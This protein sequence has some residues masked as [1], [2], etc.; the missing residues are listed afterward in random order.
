M[1]SDVDSYTLNELRAIPPELSARAVVKPRGHAS[2]ILVSLKMHLCGWFVGGSLP[3]SVNERMN[4]WM[5]GWMNECFRLQRE[6]SSKS[7]WASEMHL[8]ILGAHRGPLGL[9]SVVWMQ[10]E[11]VRPEWQ[12]EVCA[13]LSAELHTRTM[14]KPFRI[15]QSVRQ[16]Q[17][18]EFLFVFVF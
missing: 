16:I 14:K 11:Y 7:G 3:T 6:G 5:N 8:L 1:R 13:E 15:S 17:M 4:G 18:R 2:G 12:R 10:P 9:D